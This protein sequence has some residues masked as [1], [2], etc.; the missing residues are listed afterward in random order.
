VSLTGSAAVVTD[1]AQKKDLW[2]AG[3][4]AWLPQGPEDPSVALVKVDADSADYWDSPG[5]RLATALS[6]VK[7][8]ATGDKPAT[9]HHKKVDL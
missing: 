4:E 8:K 6:F 1:V 9:G 3:V 7:A 5:N 2:N